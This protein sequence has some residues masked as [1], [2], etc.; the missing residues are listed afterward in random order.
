MRKLKRIFDIA[1]SLCGLMVAL[2]VI[3]IVA[4]LL[5]LTSAGPVFFKQKRIGMHSKPFNIYKFR[6]MSHTYMPGLKPVRGEHPELT[7]LGRFLRDTSIDEVPQLWNVLKGDMSLVGPR[8]HA[9]YHV[10]YYTKH[11]PFYTRRLEVPPGITGAVQVRPERNESA[12]I[13]QVKKQVRID[14]KYIEGWT[15]GRDI[16]ICF[17]TAFMVLQMFVR[18]DK[19]EKMHPEKQANQKNQEPYS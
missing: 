2:P 11:I 10:E 6:T 4:L 16:R 15:F 17:M 14:L 7:K 9:D 8:P 3:I 5:K 18:R 19:R 13:S 1:V 12:T